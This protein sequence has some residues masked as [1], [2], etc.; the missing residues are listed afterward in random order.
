MPDPYRNLFDLTGK[1]AIVT[2]ASKGIGAAIA[3]ALAAFGA[4]VIVSSR[5][6]EAVETVARAIREAGHEAASVAAHMGDREA[7]GQLVA[8][9]R[10]R[11]GGL[12]ILVNNAATNPVFGPLLA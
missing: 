10:A 5:K 4:R 8:T 2:G 11:Y 9:T 1:T 12:D 6:P 7:I 3:H